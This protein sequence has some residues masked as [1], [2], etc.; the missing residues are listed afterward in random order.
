MLGRFNQILWCIR[1][2]LRQQGGVGDGQDLCQCSGLVSSRVQVGLALCGDTRGGAHMSLHHE[3]GH[4]LE[5]LLVLAAAGL[6]DLAEVD[7]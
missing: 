3:A 2:Y 1:H 5:V 7:P 6:T 4:A